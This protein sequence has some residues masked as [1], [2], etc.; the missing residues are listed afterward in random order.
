MLL[1]V[2][3]KEL[4]FPS[5]HLARFQC[6]INCMKWYAS[7]HIVLIVVYDVILRVIIIYIWT[8]L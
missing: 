8:L 2:N 5:F 1:F 7:I 4:V 3:R 6:S